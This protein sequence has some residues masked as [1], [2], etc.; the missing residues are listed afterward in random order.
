MVS[1]HC[2]VTESSVR[3]CSVFNLW[4]VCGTT[5]TVCFILLCDPDQRKVFHSLGQLVAVVVMISKAAN[6]VLMSC[7]CTVV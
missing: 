1:G 7:L 5:A 6:Y 2:P 4:L 3:T